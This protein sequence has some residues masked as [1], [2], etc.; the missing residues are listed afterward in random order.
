DGDL[1][2]QEV[3]A[4]DLVDDAG[5]L[6]HGHVEQLVA[7]VDAALVEGGLEHRP[8]QGMGH[9]VADEDD[10]LA[11]ACNLSS[12]SKKP[13]Y[14]MAALSGR[15]MTVRPEA[16][17]PAMAKVMARRWSARLSVASPCS[18]VGPAIRMSSPSTITSP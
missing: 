11:H 18:T 16:M 13:G 1:G 15:E 7:R 5:Q 12:S 2:A 3:R 9:R 4:A 17:R 14:E 10:A 6:G 8:G